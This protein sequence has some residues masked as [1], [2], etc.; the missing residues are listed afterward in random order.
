LEGKHPLGDLAPRH[1][2][3]KEIYEE[4]LAG[5]DVFLDIS[6]IQNFSEKFP[7]VTAICEKHRI[8]VKDGKIPVAPGCHFLMGG[9]LVNAVGKTSINGLYVV[10][11]TAATGVHGANRLASNSLLEGL[12]YGRKVAEHLNGL[13]DEGIQDMQTKEAIV[14][15]ASL[16]LPNKILLRKKMMTYGGII[17][18]QSELV[19]LEK[20]LNQYDTEVSFLDQ[21]NIEDIQKLFM[22]QAAKLVTTGALLRKESRG[23][24]NRED[25]PV[26]SEQ[27]GKVH[28]IHSQNGVEMRQKNECNQIEIHA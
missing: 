11:E 17:R 27:W 12:Y 22:L 26:E 24:H 5:K 6:K 25:F 13:E 10:G 1:I 3:A 21:F 15:I 4:R 8:S 9:V 20:W 23:A 14:N 7:T 19:K 16:S 18:K 2:V 28:I